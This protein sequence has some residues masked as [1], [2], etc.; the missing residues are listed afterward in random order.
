MEVN[1]GKAQVWNPA[2]A[3]APLQEHETQLA[4]FRDRLAAQIVDMLVLSIFGWTAAV[5]VWRR[6]GG[7]GTS[8]NR[9]RLDSTAMWAALAVMLAAAL[10]YFFLFECFAGASVGK[11]ACGLSVRSLANTRCGMVSALVRTAF[12]PI[13]TLLGP[14]FILLSR[15]AQR[16]G[17]RVAGTVVVR[18][19]P[20][21][22]QRIDRRDLPATWEE[23]TKAAIVDLTLLSMFVLAYSF[24]TGAF[25]EK[26][27][28]Q[29]RLYPWLLIPLLQVLFSYFVV[30]EG[31]FG[32]TLGKLVC[33]LQMVPVDGRTSCFASAAIRALFYPLN[34]I[35][36]G[37]LALLPMLLTQK[38]QHLGDLLA[39]AL[40][41]TQAPVNR[42]RVWV[43]AVAL[44]AI[45]VLGIYPLACRAAMRLLAAH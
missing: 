3:A 29:L 6:Y 2:G 12:R 11:L 30:L 9:I 38:R 1:A 15:N 31:I 20:V 14:P 21:A 25:G 13:D 22:T 16:L 44:S 45:A 17:D 19:P 35:S 27:Q 10:L 28:F 34:L 23:R 24:A 40:V 37:L 8:W 26:G 41:I 4:T 33:N 36:L 7:I 5:I 18:R 42:A 39:G 43:T 32:G